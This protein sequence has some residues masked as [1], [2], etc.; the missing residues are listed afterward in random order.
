MGSSSLSSKLSATPSMQ[1][2]LLLLMLRG[3]C[4]STDLNPCSPPTIQHG[5]V[6]DFD[7]NNLLHASTSVPTA[8]AC[9]EKCVH[10]DRC[11]NFAFY[12]LDTRPSTTLCVLLRSCEHW[13]SC[14]SIENCVS[15]ISGPK[16][17]SLQDVCGS[18]LQGKGCKGAKVLSQHYQISQ[19]KQCQALCE[20]NPSCRFFTQAGA[21]LC[22]LHPS[23]NTTE[24]CSSCISGPAGPG[25]DEGLDASRPTGL[26]TLLLGGWTQ[27]SSILENFSTSLE[28]VTAE[29]SC[30]PS[31]PDL[32]VGRRHAGA[33]LLGRTILYCGG[34][35]NTEK[36]SDCYSYH[37]DQEGATWEQSAS[38]VYPR[39]VFSLLAIG[40]KA[41]ALGGRG[42][43]GREYEE[44]TVEAFTP[45]EGWKIRND[46]RLPSTTAHHCS[47]AIGSRIITI[48]GHVAGTS[49]SNQVLQFDLDH[50][51]YG[52][53]RL[54]RTK[55]G[56][57]H[58]GC[59]V[60][61]YQGQQG[62]FVTGGSNK[63]HNQVEFFVNAAR[64][65]RDVI[66]SMSSNRYYH[67]SSTIGGALYSH[68]GSGSEGTQ[69]FFNETSAVW[70]SS[71]L[72][73]KRKYHTSV[74]LPEG[75]ISC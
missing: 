52:W 5:N 29:N 6:C 62:I 19:P 61:S 2:L 7:F 8:T 32:P 27:N 67:T 21:D 15:A 13:T 24:P 66:P 31:V 14:Q 53:N 56:R 71:N 35:S 49:N 72:Q 74:S 60:G 10:L 48:G 1:L 63:G 58:H 30:T 69:E 22:I 37:M 26:Q 4:T 41:Y 46:M 11:S 16:T 75:T 28:L 51:G 42:T 3:I 59:T 9:Q 44:V 36:H 39:Y 50:P 12:T 64:K 17:P 43:F 20:A 70:I 68:G 18:D 65:W 23:C 34:E 45:G 55:K 25:W 73:R 54:E 38:M 47:V 57:Q 40:G 33:T